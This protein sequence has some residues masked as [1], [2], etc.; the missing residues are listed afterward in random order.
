MNIALTGRN[1]EITDTIRTYAEEKISKFDEK[2]QLKITTASIILSVQKRRHNAE[3]VIKAKGEVIKA[4]ATTEE[5]YAAID[6]VVDKLDKQLRKSKE[7]RSERRKAAESQSK[8]EAVGATAASTG[9]AA[10]EAAVI[11]ERRQQAVKP[12][13]PE[14]AAAQLDLSD[15]SFF[16]FTN[17]ASNAVNVIYKMADGNF[18]L[19]EPA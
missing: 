4:E 15:L 19:I 10:A 1:V 13:S 8:R 17:A 7:K 14:E 12:M 9:E 3:V 18:G 11:V 6:A 2:Y 5:L 16:V